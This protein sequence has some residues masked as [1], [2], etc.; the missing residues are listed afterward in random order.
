[1]QTHPEPLPAKLLGSS[2]WFRATGPHSKFLLPVILSGVLVHRPLTY[3]RQPLWLDEAWVATIRKASVADLLSLKST[4][5]TGFSFLVWLAPGPPEALRL[6]PLAAALTIPVVAYFVAFALTERMAPGSRRAISITVSF[7][8]TISPRLL[9]R[10]DL[11]HYTFDALASLFCL[12]IITLKG[13]HISAVPFFRFVLVVSILFLISNISAFL[14]AAAFTALIVES[15]LLREWS[16]TWRLFRF[17][18]GSTLV[19]S[20]LYFVTIRPYVNKSLEGYWRGYFLPINPTLAVPKFWELFS[21]QARDLGFISGWILA[22]VLV[23]FVLLPGIPRRHVHGTFLSTLMLISYIAASSKKYPAFDSRTSLYLLV[24]LAF[25]GSFVFTYA[26]FL[27]LPSVRSNRVTDIKGLGFGLLLLASSSILVGY[28]VNAGEALRPSTIQRQSMNEQVL[29]VLSRAHPGE[30]IVVNAHGSF[31]FCIYWPAHRCEFPNQ[32]AF[33]T[34]FR[35]EVNVDPFKGFFAVSRDE[36][37]IRLALKQ[38]IHYSRT[39]ENTRF[40]VLRSHVNAAE[41]QAWSRLFD[42]LSLRV[43]PV[44][45]GIEDLLLV[46]LP[47]QPQT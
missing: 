13:V 17:F 23:L 35:A 37:S 10:N 1:M 31:G 22:T 9:E 7:L 36:S 44:D 21:G 19:I 30:A 15:M 4:S 47:A 38:A 29:G 14:I 39:Q 43:S 41:N 25:Y 20:M 28:S 34:G 5:T 16:L 32:P 6:I 12:L 33:G 26:L 46:E 27:A 11:K 8:I 40:W 24:T 3:L 42:E 18:A 45:T 2:G